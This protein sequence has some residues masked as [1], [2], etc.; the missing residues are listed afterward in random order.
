[1]RRFSRRSD[2][3]EMM[4]DLQCSGP[5]LC[6]TLHE[7]DIINRWLGGNRITLGGLNTLL[8]RIQPEEVLHIADLGCGSGMMLHY[9]YR[10]LRH[11]RNMVLTGVDANPHVIAIAQQHYPTVEFICADIRQESFRE[12][13]YD[14]VLATLFLHHFTD[15]ELVDLLA[16]LFR[17]VRVGIVINDLHRHPLAYYG[18]RLLTRLFS[19][20]PMVRFD[21]PLSVL[22]GFTRSDWEKIL[23]R[24]GITTYRLSWRWAFRWQIIIPAG[25]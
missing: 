22:R 9:L 15:D 1:M 12:K 24:A 13:K 17:Q 5:I 3:P 4:D 8:R 10:R 25:G 23:A 7:L 19:K 16:Q 14:V 18:I 6:R 2:D 11:K 21:A 20:S